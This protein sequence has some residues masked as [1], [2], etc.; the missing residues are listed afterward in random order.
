MGYIMAP[1]SKNMS[2]QDELEILNKHFKTVKRDKYGMVYVDSF[3]DMAFK[4]V[5]GDSKKRVSKRNGIK[6]QD[7]FV[8]KL[9]DA[10][11]PFVNVPTFRLK[12]DGHGV[13]PISFCQSKVS[14][15]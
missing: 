13:F 10:Y 3:L 4:E 6:I 7:I 5:L 15:Q 1:Y 8:Q 14:N 9:R 12:G 11:G 2:P